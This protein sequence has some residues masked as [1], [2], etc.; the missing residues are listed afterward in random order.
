MCSNKGKK[1]DYGRRTGKTRSGSR[2]RAL[3]VQTRSNKGKNRTPYGPRTG[4]TRSE[5]KFRGGNAKVCCYNKTIKSLTNSTQL[6]ARDKCGGTFK[7]LTCNE[8]EGMVKRC[9][10]LPDTK[11][12]CG[13]RAIHLNRG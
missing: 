12:N 7:E 4:K 8:P 5:R 10:Q 2:V 13:P 6:Y 1:R 3:P 9:Q 11:L